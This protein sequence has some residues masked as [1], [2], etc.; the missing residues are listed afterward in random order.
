MLICVFA[1]VLSL[2]LVY[3]VASFLLLELIWCGFCC[4]FRL[5]IWLVDWLISVLFCA[6]DCLW[7][8]MVSVLL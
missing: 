8:C 6:C 3:Y 7:V 4:Y 5:A 1:F 2:I